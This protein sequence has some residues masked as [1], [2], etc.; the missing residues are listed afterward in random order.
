MPR[1]PRPLPTRVPIRLAALLPTVLALL[2]LAVGCSR[3]VPPEGTEPYVTAIAPAS[4]PAGTR[5]QLTG[6]FTADVVVTLCDAPLRDVAVRTNDAD[7]AWTPIASADPDVTYDRA[8]GVVPAFPPATTCPVTLVRDGEVVP[9]PDAEAGDPPTV[10][11]HVPPERPSAPHTISVTDGDG[12]A[13]LR[14]APPDD[15]G[16]PLLRYETNL[17]GSDAWIPTDVPDGADETDKADGAE[18]FQAIVVDALTNGVTYTARVRAVNAVG[19]G[20]PSAWVTL[21]PYGPPGAVRD[22]VATTDATTLTLTFRPPPPSGRPLTNLEVRLD[23]GPWTPLDPPRTTSPVSLTDRTPD[24]AYDVGLRGVNAA[25]PGTP[26]TLEGVTTAPTPSEPTPDEPDAPT[27]PDEPDP[28][29]DPDPPAD[30]DPT[31]DPPADPDP[32]FDA[33]LPTATFTA[34]SAGPTHGLALTSSGDVWAWGRNDLGQSARTVPDIAPSLTPTDAGVGGGVP[35]VQTAAG[36]TSGVAIDALGRLW[37]FGSDSQGQRGRTAPTQALV[38]SLSDAPWGAG[39]SIVDVAAGGFHVLALDETGV[40]WAW[41]DGSNGVLG[42][43]DTADVVTP[44]RTDA[45]WTADG[46]TIT[47]V[48]TFGDVSLARDDT[49]NLWSWGADDRGQLGQHEANSGSVPGPVARDWADESGAVTDVAAGG[50]HALAVDGSGVVWAWGSNDEGQLA[51]DTGLP[52]ISFPIPVQADLAGVTVVRVAAGA[53]HSLALDDQGRV[54]A[55][56]RNVEGQLGT[57]GTDARITTPTL[58]D[59][60]AWAAHGV[61]ITDV[62]AGPAH[63]LAIDTEGRIWGWGDGSSAQLT[64]ELSSGAR[65]PVKLSEVAP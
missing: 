49:G 62:V 25:G 39:V 27:T 57:G 16:R 38:P 1:T 36:F 18:D 8:R 50:Q 29:E 41:G 6:R 40:V 5:V 7:A 65:T 56:G 46:R 59:D 55:W 26:A 47:D 21:T 58:T 15:R 20:A 64:E 2:A 3:N 31:D 60:E 30:P 45:P 12:R 19:P 37:T 34:T 32:P 52:Q 13:T 23:D 33:T 4:G 42:T 24:T 11:F 44:T 14:F 51:Q 17:S 63:S 43:G 61:S 53:D 28:P 10:T 54:W 35:L 48:T 22:L 9:H